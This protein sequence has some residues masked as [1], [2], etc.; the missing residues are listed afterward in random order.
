ME[1]TTRHEKGEK[2]IMFDNF[3]Q[4]LIIDAVT[5]ALKTLSVLTLLIVATWLMVG[6]FLLLLIG[7]SAHPHTLHPAPDFY[8]AQV[9]Q[10]V[11]VGLNKE[12]PWDKII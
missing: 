1:R 10:G 2:I 4:L 7:C 5:G 6:I 9:K 11:S 3:A 12:Y 8:L